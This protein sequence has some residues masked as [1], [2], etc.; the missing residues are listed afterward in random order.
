M[1]IDDFKHWIKVNEKKNKQFELTLIDV[2]ENT[3]DKEVDNSVVYTY[4]ND[5][6]ISQF[7]I[8]NDGFINI[9]VLRKDNENLVFYIYCMT[10]KHINFE[11]LLDNYFNYVK[12]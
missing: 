7:T 5:T 10:D 8:R 3:C 9:E 2:Y 11:S 1:I 4:E 6:F 12:K